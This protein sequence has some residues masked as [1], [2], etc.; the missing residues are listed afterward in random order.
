M[1]W[2]KQATIWCDGCPKWTGHGE[3]KVSRARAR[4]AKT[5]W[6]YVGGKDYCSECAKDLRDGRPLIHA[7]REEEV[8]NGK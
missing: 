8:N 7:V 2:S 6:I 4:A 5:G 1:T 3:A